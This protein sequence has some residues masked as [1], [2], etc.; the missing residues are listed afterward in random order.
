MYGYMDIGIKV[1]SE[2]KIIEN[3]SSSVAVAYWLPL[4]SSRNKMYIL[5]GDSR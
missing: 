2:R 1:P 3:W 4:Q 5:T